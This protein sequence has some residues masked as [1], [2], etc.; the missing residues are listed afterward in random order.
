MML[1]VYTVSILM[2]ELFIFVVIIHGLVHIMGFLRAFHFIAPKGYSVPATK[3]QGILWLLAM[4]LFEGMAVMLIM[5]YKLWWLLGLVAVT[6]SQILIIK[7]WQDSK[8]GTL[9]N[10]LI[11]F[12][13]IIDIGVWHV[14]V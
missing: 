5:D 1:V 11:F 8:F 2:K 10:I 12:T 3:A 14:I 4:V 13:I 7:S 6:V 9:V